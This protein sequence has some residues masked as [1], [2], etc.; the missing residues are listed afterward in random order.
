MLGQ[1]ANTLSLLMVEE[2]LSLFTLLPAGGNSGCFQPLGIL[3]LQAIVYKVLP[4]G[5]FSPLLSMYLSWNG[6]A[7]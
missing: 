6:W 5:M 1:V 4:G 3:L 2:G 7:T